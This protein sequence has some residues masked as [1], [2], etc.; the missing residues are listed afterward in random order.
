MKRAAV[1]ILFLIALLVGL[2]IAVPTAIAMGEPDDPDDNGAVTQDQ[3]AAN[4]A[5]AASKKLGTI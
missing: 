1:S 4:S 2:N 5:A 3:H